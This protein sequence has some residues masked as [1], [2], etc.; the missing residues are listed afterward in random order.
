[1]PCIV[2]NRNFAHKK[3]NLHKLKLCTKKKTSTRYCKVEFHW[4]SSL[5]MLLGLTS[6]LL[7]H[8]IC[9]N[10]VNVTRR[11]NFIFF[12]NYIKSKMW[13]SL[14][15]FLKLSLNKVYFR[16]IWIQN[17]IGCWMKYLRVKK[18]HPSMKFDLK[19]KNRDNSVPSFD[20]LKAM[21]Q[22][23]WHFA[24]SDCGSD[25]C[26]NDKWR[27]FKCNSI[28]KSVH[29]KEHCPPP[30]PDKPSHINIRIAACCLIWRPVVFLKSSHK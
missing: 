6:H 19:C 27:A 17:T 9:L 15:Y 1:M 11:Q 30:S 28:C 23:A 24:E 13:I 10:I 20:S 3:E 26:L 25:E 21:I 5:E 8:K 12:T 29:E 18:T 14:D 16:N 4:F 7:V 22:H 2:T